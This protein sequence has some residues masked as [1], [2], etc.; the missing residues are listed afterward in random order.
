MAMSQIK[1]DEP[2][3][4]RRATGPRTVAWQAVQTREDMQEAFF[5]VESIVENERRVMPHC[6][7]NIPNQTEHQNREDQ[8]HTDTRGASMSEEAH[9]GDQF[10]APKMSYEGLDTSSSL[11]FEAVRTPSQTVLPGIGELPSPSMFFFLS[12]ASSALSMSPSWYQTSG[13]PPL[14]LSSY[15]SSSASSSSSS[16]SSSI[17]TASST[18]SSSTSSTTT[19]SLSTGP[20]LVPVPSLLPLSASTLIPSPAPPQS[21]L[22]SSSTS[23]PPCTHINVPTE[24]QMKI[25]KGRPRRKRNRKI[26]E[27]Y[28]KFATPTPPAQQPAIAQPP[29]MNTGVH[30]LPVQHMQQQ[31][32]QQHQQQQ[33]R[34]TTPTLWA[35][36]Q[37]RMVY[38]MPPNAMFPPSPGLSMCYPSPDVMR[39]G[40]IGANGM[41]IQMVPSPAMMASPSFLPPVASRPVDDRI[42]TPRHDQVMFAAPSPSPS[43]SHLAP[44]YGV[45]QNKMTHP[46]AMVQGQGGVRLAPMMDARFG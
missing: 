31:Q 46:G 44:I 18:S 19:S 23:F 36:P 7:T 5:R 9:A 22:S 8:T 34:P 15:P 6:S 16:S 42:L 20:V 25:F 45:P 13:M 12:P 27:D 2:S 21:L 30:Y 17:P 32:Q 11:P 26:P 39:N 28:T 33:Q 4:K 41:P 40:H 38:M 35:Q 43:R 14:S 37:P 3:P 10:L 1:Q 29:L 24:E